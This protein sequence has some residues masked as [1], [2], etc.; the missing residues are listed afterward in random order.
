MVKEYTVP[1]SRAYKRTVNRQDDVVVCGWTR[2][3]ADG[4]M[5]SKK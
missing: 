1:M 3:K 5:K 2:A 4:S